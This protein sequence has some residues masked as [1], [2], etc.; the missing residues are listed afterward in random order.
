M[1]EM[2]E[3][4][5]DQKAG[6]F[7]ANAFTDRYEEAVLGIIKAKIKGE[8]PIVAKAPQA[9]KVINLMDALRQS[10]ATSQAVSPNAKGVAPEAGAELKP[11]APSQKRRSVSRKA[12]A[13]EG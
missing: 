10:L 8:Q 1:L 13:A 2:A 11:P 6:P 7:D 4:L 3:R 12:K 5:I 9:G